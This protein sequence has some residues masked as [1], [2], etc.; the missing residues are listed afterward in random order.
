MER[1]LLM[2]MIDFRCDFAKWFENFEPKKMQGFDIID[3][4]DPIMTQ[5]VVPGEKGYSDPSVI[6]DNHDEPKNYYETCPWVTLD[7]KPYYITKITMG[8]HVATHIDA[9]MHVKNGCTI[10]QIK[11][12]L[13]GPAVVIDLSDKLTEYDLNKKI[14]AVKKDVSIVVIRGKSDY[15]ISPTYRSCIIRSKPLAVVFG[16]CVNVEG[17]SDT[18]EYLSNDIPMVMGANDEG[19]GRLK[20]ED[21]IFALPIKIQG[22]EAAPTRL[23]ALRPCY[24]DDTSENDSNIFKM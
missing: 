19:L 15:V 17:V 20:D 16:N 9:P 1:S 21:I 23:F 24:V 10:D 6:I 5:S 12:E 11:Q 2:N 14:S 4:S 18:I 7:I 22:I 8:A 3:L 13:V